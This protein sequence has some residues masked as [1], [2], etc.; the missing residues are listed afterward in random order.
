MIERE[1]LN[2]PNDKVRDIVTK[3]I[4]EIEKGNRDF[5]F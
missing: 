5:R 4:V 2:V 3:N 1:I